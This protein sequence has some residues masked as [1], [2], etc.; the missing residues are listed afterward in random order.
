MERLAIL[1]LVL[2]V[3]GAV[4]SVGFW[5]LASV[6]GAELLAA[7]STGQYGPGSRVFIREKVVD[8]AYTNVF[9]ANRTMLELEDGDPNAGTYIFVHGDARPG[10]ARGSYYY[11]SAT[12]TSY[13]LGT[14]W[15]VASPAEIQPSL[16]IDALFFA[17]LVIGVLLLAIVAFRKPAKSK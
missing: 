2:T 3:S 16:P 5:P 14:Y 7:Q 15:D 13:G 4:L 9:G 17:D 1:G 8:L 11:F 6:S 10:V 12:R